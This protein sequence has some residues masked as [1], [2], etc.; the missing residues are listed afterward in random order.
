ML[1]RRC[2][3]SGNGVTGAQLAVCLG[4]VWL[5]GKDFFQGFDG[6]GKAVFVHLVHRRVP[7]SVERCLN[8]HHFP[9]FAARGGCGIKTQGLA[10]GADG[11]HES[12]VLTEGVGLGQPML[13]QSLAKA[14]RLLPALGVRLLAMVLQQHLLPRCR[15]DAY[16]VLMRPDGRHVLIV[17]G[18]KEHLDAGKARHVTAHAVAADRRRQPVLLG[19]IGWLMALQ[20][21]ALHFA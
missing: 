10:G 20:A 12:V 9:Q 18:V 19:T 21:G 4:H 3:L 8:G 2:V 6:L 13:D 16:A 7:V 11:S 14:F 5:D 17:L 1:H 15:I